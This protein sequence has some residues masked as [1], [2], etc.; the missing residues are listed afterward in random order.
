MRVGEP[1][2]C[3]KVDAPTCKRLEERSCI[4]GNQF[5]VVSCFLKDQFH[6]VAARDGTVPGDIADPDLFLGLSCLCAGA[7]G[8]EETEHQNNTCQCEQVSCFRFMILP[9]HRYLFAFSE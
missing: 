6:H 3:R 1:S 4:D 5:D 8:R 9:Q 7:T 2:G